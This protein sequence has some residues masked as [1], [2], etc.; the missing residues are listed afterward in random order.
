MTECEAC[1][2]FKLCS[3]LYIEASRYMKNMCKC[4]LA[5]GIQLL[6]PRLIKMLPR[7]CILSEQILLRDTEM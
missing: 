4:V 1:W 3:P 7:K 5:V 2:V 6:I